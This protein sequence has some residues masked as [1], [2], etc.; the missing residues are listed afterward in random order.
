MSDF[1]INIPGA[2]I[3]PAPPA[4]D[5][6]LRSM[7]VDVVCGLNEEVEWHWAMTDRGRLASGYSVTRRLPRL[8]ESHAPAESEGVTPGRNVRSQKKG[9]AR[10]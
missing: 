6:R 2:R 8:N 4:S 1:A 7:I 10:R 3:V 9:I 5:P